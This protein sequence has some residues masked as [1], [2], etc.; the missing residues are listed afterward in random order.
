MRANT[1]IQPSYL[2]WLR[3]KERKIHCQ[4]FVRQYFKT[5]LRLFGVTPYTY[6]NRLSCSLVDDNRE[7]SFTFPGTANGKF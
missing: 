3:L 5:F 6:M 4:Y 2:G 7:L 1:S